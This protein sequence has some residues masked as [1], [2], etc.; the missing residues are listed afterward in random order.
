L[1]TTLPG[2]RA[3]LVAAGLLAAAP[4]LAQSDDAKPRFPTT[5]F[6]DGATSASVTAGGVTAGISMVRRPDLDPDEDVPILGVFIGDRKVLEAAGVASGFDFPA[7]EASIAEIDPDNGGPEVYFTSYSGGAHCCSTVTVA[8][9]VGGRW[10]AVPVGEFDGDGNYLE[11]LNDDGIA[12]IATVDNRFLYQF[13]CYACSAA[14]LVIMTVKGGKV[15]DVS[16]DPRFLAANREWLGQIEDAV[17]PAERW[18]SP[19]YLAGWVAAKAR[20]GE[21]EAAM[22]EVRA[23]WNLADDEGEEVC[24]TGGDPED[25]AKKNRAVLKFPDRLE[26]F[27]RQT[28]Y[29]PPQ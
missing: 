28:G 26:L 12:E 22:R 15:A 20:V 24:L 25:C 6:A 13:D 18:T 2:L 3:A 11:D 29:L 9:E 14:P 5:E 23:R 7:A 4:A 16:T 10:T 8:D 27:L 17:D 1:S 19:G 21:G